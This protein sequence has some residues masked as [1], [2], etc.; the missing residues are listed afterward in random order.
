MDDYQVKW[1]LVPGIKTQ[2]EYDRARGVFLY[3]RFYKGQ[4]QSYVKCRLAPAFAFIFLHMPSQG[5]FRFS[6][7]LPHA[8]R[9]V[10]RRY[11]VPAKHPMSVL[12][13]IMMWSMIL[14]IED[15]IRR[16]EEEYQIYLVEP[17]LSPHDDT[18][19]Q[20]PI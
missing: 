18:L 2:A 11:N 14:D 16:V 13:K 4:Q 19:K 20:G 6:S 5:G 8:R 12:A 7:D 1:K 10:T 9:M 3:S 17:L 15:C